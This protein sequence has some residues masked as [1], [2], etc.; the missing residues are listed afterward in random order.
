MSFGFSLEPFGM[1]VGFDYF[2]NQWLQSNGSMKKKEK[3]KKKEKTCGVSSENFIT[4]TQIQ[5]SNNLFQLY[6]KTSDS[7][8]QRRREI[9]SISLTESDT[10]E[11]KQSILLQVLV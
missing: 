2:E 4:R 11:E 1:T 9:S 5:I 8:L 6:I 7:K 3:S 10:E